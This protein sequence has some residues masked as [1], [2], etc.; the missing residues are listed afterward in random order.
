MDKTWGSCGASEH[1]F[2]T[3]PGDLAVTLVMLDATLTVE[4]ANGSTRVL[5]V[6]DLHRLPGS[7]PHIETA[8]NSGDLIMAIN[9]PR[10]DWT[11][12]TYVKL[13]DRAS[14]AFA[15]ASAAVALR[16]DGATVVAARVA[17][18]GVASVPWRCPAVED[19]LT[20]REL[21]PAAAMQA[22]AA[23][24]AEALGGNPD[25]MALCTRVLAKALLVAGKTRQGDQP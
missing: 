5:K 25:R 9:L 14:Y 11:G 1:C 18:G 13:R 6:G 17:L 10:P 8:L 4:G 3:Y 7:T 16:M 21:S 2:A 22:G 20:G 19:W 23:L 12:Q 15:S 24:F